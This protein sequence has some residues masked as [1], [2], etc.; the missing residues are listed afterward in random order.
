M[1]IYPAID[2]KDGRCV[3][4]KQGSFDDVTVFGDDPLQTAL[5]F[6]SQGATF[7]HVVDLDGARTGSAANAEIL[8][9]LAKQLPIPVQTGGG[10]RTM[11]DIEQKLATGIHRVILGTAA[12]KNPALVQQA[13]MKFGPEAIAVGIDAKD[14]MVAVEGWE[15]IS[16]RSA[17]DL[18]KE[19]GAYGVRHII[20]TDIAK[21]GMMA[22]PSV[23]S[24]KNLIEQTGLSVIASGGI[25][26]LEDLKKVEQAGAAGAIIGK[27]LY[28]GAI[29]LAEAIAQFEGAEGRA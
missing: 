18:A 6:V 28:L 14:G 26:S 19:M 7:L 23:E 25:S 21:D 10:I 1:Q 29:H 12:V 8:R 5:G 16:A 20:Y 9:T 4:L 15:Q 24:L 3:R 17:V 22:G 27:A 11:T 2:L 13:V